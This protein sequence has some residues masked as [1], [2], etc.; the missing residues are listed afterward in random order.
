MGTT[1]LPKMPIL[2]TKDMPSPEA[3][4]YGKLKH[5]QFLV[6]ILD[7]DNKPT[8]MTIVTT[9]EAGEELFHKMSERREFMEDD[10]AFRIEQGAIVI[11]EFPIPEQYRLGD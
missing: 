9:I 6:R 3:D 5:A 7:R 11:N 4:G 10:M 2:T 8:F 1:T